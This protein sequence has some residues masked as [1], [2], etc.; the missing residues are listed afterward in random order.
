MARPYSS[1]LAVS[2]GTALLQIGHCGRTFSLRIGRG[3]ALNVLRPLLKWRRIR[4]TTK[5]KLCIA[6]VTFCGGRKSLRKSYYEIRF[7]LKQLILRTLP[8]TVLFGADRRFRLL[9]GGAAKG[10]HHSKT[11]ECFGLALQADSRFVSIASG[12]RTVRRQPRLPLSKA[13]ISS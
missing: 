13:S 12:G 5:G 4:F 10:N 6:S 8:H 9:P 1:A 3:Y 2:R 7:C 11:E